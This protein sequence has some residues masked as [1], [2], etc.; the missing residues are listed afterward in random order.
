M[1]ILKPCASYDAVELDFR[2]RPVVGYRI[3]YKTSRAYAQ[4]YFGT[5]THDF[6]TED[7]WINVWACSEDVSERSMQAQ[8][9]VK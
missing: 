5:W 7:V 3:T 8:A 4:D 6:E 9:Q 1:R 2:G